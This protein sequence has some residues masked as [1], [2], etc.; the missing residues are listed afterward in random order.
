MTFP[1]DLPWTLLLTLLKNENKSG[2]QEVTGKSRFRASDIHTWKMLMHWPEWSYLNITIQ[3]YEDN[4]KTN[5]FNIQMWKMKL[6]CAIRGLNNQIWKMSKHWPERPSLAFNCRQRWRDWW[7]ASC[8]LPLPFHG[9]HW[10]RKWV[11][12]WHCRRITFHY[13]YSPF[14]L[15]FLTVWRVTVISKGVSLVQCLC[16]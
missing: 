9:Q 4:M 7:A 8:H 14:L 5:C 12:V 15:W 13:Y 10:F 2:S 11:P 3:Q 16:E 6:R 1:S